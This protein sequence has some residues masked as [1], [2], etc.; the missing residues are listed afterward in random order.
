MGHT[1]ENLSPEA[2]EMARAMTGE[3]LLNASCAEQ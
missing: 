3:Q 1:Y 2:K